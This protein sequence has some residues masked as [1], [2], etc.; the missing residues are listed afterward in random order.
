MN[1]RPP[2]Q[3]GRPPSGAEILSSF[4]NSANTY[5]APTVGLASWQSQSLWLEGT[6]R[7]VRDKRPERPEAQR[8]RRTGSWRGAAPS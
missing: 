4:I 3:D 2:A 5:E 1:N 8:R 6:F 7:E